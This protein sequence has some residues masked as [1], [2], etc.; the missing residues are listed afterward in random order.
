[1]QTSLT[2]IIKRTSEGTEAEAIIRSCVHCGFC[3]ATCPTYQLLGNELDSPRGRIYLIKEAL[4]GK[5]VTVKTQLHLDR[6]LTCRACETT[7]P[8]GVQYG[9]LLDIG[10]EHVERQ[11][12]RKPPAAVFRYALRKLFTHQRAFAALMRVARAV[13]PLLS[14]ELRRKV[15][16]YRAAAKRPVPR[17][18]RKMLLLDGCVQPVLDP[19]INS[20]AVAVLDRIGISLVAVKSAGCCGGVAHH[21]NA[22]REALAQ[23]KRNIDAWWPLV[24]EGAEAIV[25]TASG[26]GPMLHDYGH[27]LRDDPQYAKRAVRVASLTRDVSQVIADHRDALGEVLREVSLGA[28]PSR[29]AFHSPCTLQ[30]GLKLNGVVEQILTAAGFQL[31]NVTDSHLCCG[32]AGTYSIL[33]PELSGQLL[34]NKITALERDSPDVIAS[35]NIGCLMHLRTATQTPI[36]HW[37]ELLAGR[38]GVS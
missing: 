17:H 28:R 35:A 23:V 27:L 37:I 13:S 31:L 20:A 30:H 38:L 22:R 1:M 16:A 25:V 2:D 8:S 5:Q 21:M 9:R 10:R 7:C 19:A 4:E 15:P 34:Q 11:V 6:C 29:V 14:Q 32:S 18:A 12:E 3:L 33:Q 26:C 36:V 24:E